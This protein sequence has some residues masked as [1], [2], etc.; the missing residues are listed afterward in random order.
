MKRTICILSVM[1]MATISN[2][3]VGQT[4]KVKGTYQG[5]TIVIEYQVGAPGKDYVSSIKYKPFDD[6]LEAKNRLENDRAKSEKKIKELKAEVD[7]LRGTGSSS[8]ELALLQT[9]LEK[10][11]ELL[12][13][14]ND[15][16]AK[17]EEEITQLRNDIQ[18]WK[19]NLKSTQ[20]RL[21]NAKKQASDYAE[22]LKRLQGSK[23]NK[24]HINIMAFIASSTM[25]NDLTVQE[26]WNQKA[27]LGQSYQLTYTKYFSSSSPFAITIGAGFE[28]YMFSANI[29]FFK[30]YH[31]GL[32]D[33]DGDLMDLGF[34]YNDIMENVSLSYLN[35]P[36]ELHVG[37][38]KGKG[39]Q[40][41]MDAGLLLSFNTRCDF[42]GTGKYSKY[43]YYPQWDMTIIDEPLLGLTKSA[44]AYSGETQ[45]DLNKTVLWGMLGL[46]VNVS[47]SSRM[48]IIAGAKCAYS[49]T[50]VSKEM[51]LERVADTQY[52]FGVS[53]LL[54]GK[55]TRILN[56]G[57]SF[58]ISYSFEPQ[59]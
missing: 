23:N 59:K 43:A 40:V 50:A 32:K 19:E 51:E 44:D 20:D 14:T 36:V 48:A 46:G 12:N 30:E 24:D 16:L 2:N 49:L 29:P 45:W 6:L 13:R 37:N 7:K 22:E 42:E 11:Q 1:L 5:K 54:G 38:N 4:H 53:N 31:S 3:L 27:S 17:K 41:W 26:P 57:V 58:G 25:Y 15:S 55:G 8:K 56:W 52:H 47:L 35:V 33:P 10:N 34:Q 28:E 18:L 9:E 39:C 21:T